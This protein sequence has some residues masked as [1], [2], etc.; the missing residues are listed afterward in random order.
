MADF[1][2]NRSIALQPPWPARGAQWPT[3]RVSVQM[4][5]YELT[6]DN[7]WN[8]AAHR[9]NL[10]NFTMTTCDAPTRN[11][12]PE[13]K[14]LSIALLVVSSLFVLQRFG[15]KIYK[16]TELG[17]DDWLTLVALLHLLSIT[18]TN[19][20]LVRNGLGRDVWTLR[21]ETI[22]NFG[23]YFFIKVVLYMSEVAVLKLAILFF[24]LR[25]FPDER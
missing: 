1:H 7:A 24:Y 13:Y 11:K 8:K 19:T 14:N 21:P 15:F 5:R 16:G 17:I 18:I 9:K 4:Y 3:P 10:W 23:K 2:A 6:W 25:I 20:E 12:G 22:N